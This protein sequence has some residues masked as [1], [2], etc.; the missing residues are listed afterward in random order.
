MYTVP[1]PSNGAPTAM[2]GKE[3]YNGVTPPETMGPM[4]P[5][6]CA[7]PTAQHDLDLT[8]PDSTQIIKEQSSAA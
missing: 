5:Q 2:S 3:K 6:P 8:L 1:K 4:S 7:P